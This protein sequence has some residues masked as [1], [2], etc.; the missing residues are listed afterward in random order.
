[1]ARRAL[2][3]GIDAYTTIPLRGCVSDAERIGEVLRRHEDGS[4][5][6]DARLLKAPCGGRGDAVT[7]G[8]LLDQVGELFSNRADIAVLH[9]SGHGTVNHLDGYLVTQDARQYSEGASMTEIL[10]MAN[11]SRAD[12]VVVLLDC[13]HSGQLGNISEIDNTSALLREGV[14]IITAS[15]GDQPSVETEG[16]G[17]FTSLVLDALQGG[18]ADLLGS[19]TVPAVY[20]YVETALGAW[21]QRP[22]F[23]AH[24]SRLS[25]LRRCTPPIEP[26][27]L[28]ELPCLFPLPAEDF[29]LDPSYE[30]TSAMACLARVTEFGRLQ[31]LNRVHLVVPVAEAH[32]YDA[33]MGSKAC[34]LTPSGRY[35]WRL[36]KDG[37]I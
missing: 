15:R 6:F 1:M 19:V 7:R 10:R 12:E 24:L 27:I 14:A 11:E 5:N 16:G 36:A 31:A 4:P 18:A 23:K 29:Q 25:P 33:A 34:R 35:Y 9:F 22:L 3:V 28:R 20:S 26:A 32:M 2:C 13:C 21:D 17:V 37:R 8:V 30:R